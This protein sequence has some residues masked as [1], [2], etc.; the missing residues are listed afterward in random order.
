[1]RAVECTSTVEIR[2][3]ASAFNPAQF[4]DDH[5][6]VH[7]LAVDDHD[8]QRAGCSL[9]WSE[10]PKLD[11]H[12]VGVIGHYSASNNP[13]AELLLR[14]ATRRLRDAGC[15]CAIGPMD[16]STWRRYRFVTD[17]GQ[18]PAFFLEPQNPQ[19]WPL[20]FLLRGFSPVASYCSAIN[21]NLSCPA[22]RSE[23]TAARLRSMGVVMRSLRVGEVRWYLPHIYRL[24][25]VAFRNNFLF[26]DLPENDFMRLY[27]K[28][29][30][31][32]RPELVIVAEQQTD[33]VG[34]LFA[35]PDILR[36]RSGLPTDTF[37]IKT[38][39]ILPRRELAGLGGIMVE[40]VQQIGKDLGFSRCI[41]ALMDERNTL[42]RNVSNSYAQTMRR[43][44][45]YA[46]DLR[47]S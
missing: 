9:W 8:G 3:L 32:V 36:Q 20:Q 38:V 23:R 44:T 29:L 24:C 14:R 47:F 17:V 43:Y 5:A 16:G 12:R 6:D 39:A 37:I 11:T 19:E 35:V 4:E 25:R 40:L 13:A 22:R 46:K 7:L 26:A 41:H 28:I 18:E 2:G 33:L 27:E 15:T 10:V 34:F 30:A 21:I 1:M 31:I 45:L 42:A